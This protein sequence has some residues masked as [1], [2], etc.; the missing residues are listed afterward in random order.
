MKIQIFLTKSLED[1]IDTNR[2]SL[3]LYSYIIF[4]LK[5]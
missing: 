4:Q 3:V 2:G 1:D 5:K